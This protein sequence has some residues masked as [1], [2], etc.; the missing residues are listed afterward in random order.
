M[1]I[2][3]IEKIASDGKHNA[4]TTMTYF[5]GR[6]FIAFRRGGKHADDQGTQVVMISDNG[7]QWNILHEKR[8]LIKVEPGQATDYRDSAFLT[9][10]DE[11]RIYSFSM[12]FDLS[13]ERLTRALQ[14]TVQISRDG[15]AWSEPEVISHGIV[16]WKPIFWKG[17]FWCAGYHK[18]PHPNPS[19]VELYHSVDGLAWVS[20]GRI[21]VGNETALVPTG[22]GFRAF[23]RTK[24][25]PGHMEIWECGLDLSSWK[26]MAVIPK[27]IQAPQVQF[28]EGTC[29][30]IGRDLEPEPRNSAL[31]RTKIWKIE[32][33][34][35]VEVLELPS[36]GD[37]SYAGTALTPDGSLLVSYY[38]Q[39]EINDPNPSEDNPI[40][41]PADLFVASIAYP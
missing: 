25:A 26:R 35:A 17:E 15:L 14:S 27:T 36:C 11:L 29:Y 5:K 41:K 22:E 12:P 40:S 21:A 13:G 6:Y 30:L 23:V 33:T 4:F 34:E 2:Q 37:T 32:G 16:Q 19:V 7:R 31:R 8:E 1:N 38:S 24:L 18:E 9:L 3:W 39:H 28:I 10:E 20:K